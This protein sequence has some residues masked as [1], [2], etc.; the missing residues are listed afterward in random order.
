M[1]FP[2]DSLSRRVAATVPMDT[3]RRIWQVRGA[4]RM[5]APRTVRFGPG[6]RLYVA[7][8]ARDRVF[9]FTDSGRFAGTVEGAALE[10]PR[11]VGG[12]D[13][14]LLVLSAPRR[15]LYFATGADVADSLRLP[16]DG[17]GEEATVGVARATGDVFVKVARD[18]AVYVTR[19]DRQGNLVAR[20]PLPPPAWRRAG[21]LAVWDGRLLSTTRYRPVVD[22]LPVDLWGPL[23]TLALVGFDSPMLARTRSYALGEIVHPPVLTEAVVPAGPWLFVLNVRPGWL[24]VDVFDRQG[25]LAYRLTQADQSY[26]RNYYPRDLAV[27]RRPDGSYDLAVVLTHPEPALALY[28]W[29]PPY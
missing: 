28:R 19:L 10:Q 9:V 27:R 2:S 24:R 29:R 1:L 12:G 18:T 25:R 20:R 15:M 23:D 17:A 4:E 26:S 21:G 5:E 22:L 13:D 8:A 16:L 14:T 3:L 11:L 7:D 6:G